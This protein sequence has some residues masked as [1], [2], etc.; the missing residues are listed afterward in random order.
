M[1]S[2]VIEKADCL[3]FLRRRF[4]HESVWQLAT[5]CLFLRG[6]LN[7]HHRDGTRSRQNAGGPSVLVAYG[8][9][10]AL[11]LRD[12]GIKGAFVWLAKS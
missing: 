8:E 9:Y 3:E 10:N 1:A 6:R 4:F 11:A 12:S 2:A 7:F 5:A